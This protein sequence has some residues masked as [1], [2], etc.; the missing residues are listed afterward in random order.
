MAATGGGRP[1]VSGSES[2]SSRE[3][4]RLERRGSDSKG[5]LSENSLRG[6][7]E[8]MGMSWE[9]HRVEDVVVAVALL[10]MAVP[11]WERLGAQLVEERAIMRGRAEL[12]VR[13]S[14][15][16]ALAHLITFNLYD[17]LSLQPLQL[18]ERGSLGVLVW[19]DGCHAR[20]CISYCMSRHS[21]ILSKP[22]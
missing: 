22:P 9:V 2:R 15:F 1:G 14:P 12:S 16:L 20:Y 5:F 8:D 17:R 10:E 4:E 6:E 21:S 13:C 3:R 19:E 11:E 7:G 18:T